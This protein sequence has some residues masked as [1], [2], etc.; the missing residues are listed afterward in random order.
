MKYILQALK[1]AVK[2]KDLF[3]ESLCQAVLSKA[4]YYNDQSGNAYQAIGKAIEILENNRDNPKIYAGDKLAIYYS[5][6]ADYYAQG[7]KHEKAIESAK[8]G[9]LTLERMTSQ[10]LKVSS[11]NETSNKYWKASFLSLIS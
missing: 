2:D 6:Q 9:L 10:E 11:L 4:Y 1:R 7:Q 3:Y 5:V 8:K